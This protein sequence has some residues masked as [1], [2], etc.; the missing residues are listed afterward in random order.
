MSIN[1]IPKKYLSIIKSTKNYISN[2]DIH[3]VKDY[4]NKIRFSLSIFTYHLPKLIFI[5][6]F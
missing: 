6:L 5:F 1:I 2:N 4:I 3:A